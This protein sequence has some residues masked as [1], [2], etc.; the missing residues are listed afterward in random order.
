MSELPVLPSIVEGAA[1]PR[2]AVYPASK[3]GSKN[4]SFSSS[5]YRGRP[6]LSYDIAQDAVCAV[7]LQFACV[8]GNK[9]PFITDGYRDWKHALDSS[10][11]SNRY[12][13]GFKKHGY[14]N[15]HIKSCK[16]YLEK[17]L[18]TEKNETVIVKPTEQ[19]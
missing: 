1:Q 7:C 6:W 9:G 17:K 16:D 2:R 3:F 12:A 5:W 14:S 8:D 15:E 4:H 19:H 18:C 10:R 13:K 11:A